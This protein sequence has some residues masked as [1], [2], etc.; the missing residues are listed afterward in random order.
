MAR[1]SVEDILSGE[2]ELIDA[3]IILNDY[4]LKHTGY[5]ESFIQNRKWAITP[6]ANGSTTTPPGGFVLV[7]GGTP[8]KFTFVIANMQGD[9][10]DQIFWF[11]YNN[12]PVQ[13]PHRAINVRA[14]IKTLIC[15]EGYKYDDHY[16]K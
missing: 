15:H 13:L 14:A 10:A 11:Y 3:R 7:L 2:S 9:I 8:P 6:Y 1:H 16:A 4:V 5:E 12:S